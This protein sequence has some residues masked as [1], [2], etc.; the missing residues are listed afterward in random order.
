MVFRCSDA[1]MLY[2]IVTASVYRSVAVNDEG[3]DLTLGVWSQIPINNLGCDGTSDPSYNYIDIDFNDPTIAN[4][5]TLVLL[6]K[7][8]VVMCEHSGSVDQIDGLINK[9]RS[10]ITLEPCDFLD[11]IDGAWKVHYKFYNDIV[12][13][14]IDA[15]LAAKLF[16]NVPLK[17]DA[18]LFVKNKIVEAGIL[19]GYDAPECVKA[20]VQMEF[21]E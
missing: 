15:A 6:K 20:K 11:Y 8:T 18:E 7:I 21:A 3:E 1:A 17:S 2:V 12:S 16:D 19:E 14:P 5:Q 4:E 9:N 13:S 10:I